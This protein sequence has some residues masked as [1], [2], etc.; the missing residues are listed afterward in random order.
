MSVKS[1][2]DFMKVLKS[3]VAIGL[4]IC[5]LTTS[6]YCSENIT[7]TFNDVQADD[8]YFNAVE[9]LY[10]NGIT[11]GDGLGNYLPDNEITLNA[12]ATMLVRAFNNTNDK[13]GVLPIAYQN[14]WIDMYAVSEDPNSPIKRGNVYVSI[15]KAAEIDV[16]SETNE[17]PRW[18]DY[19]LVLN[20]L[21]LHDPSKD[22]NK[23]ITRKEV[24]Q[25]LYFVLNEKYVPE[26]P[27][28]LKDIK[29][30]NDT[31][32][33][34]GNYT[35]DFS[36]IPYPIIEKFKKEKWEIHINEKDFS[37]YLNETGIVATGLCD[38]KNK[39]ISLKAPYALIHE[40]GHFIDY[41]SD[42]KVGLD[43]LYNIE[44]N[45]FEKH[46]GCKITNSREYFANYFECFIWAKTNNEEY[47]FLTENTPKTF[48]Y[49][50]NL[51]ENNW[52]IKK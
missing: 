12:F 22:L 1:D 44:G 32:Q 2:N 47:V 45:I 50:K 38:Y 40:F 3:L 24:A 13:A 34:L 16:F 23:G 52:E 49:F 18:E 35:Y 6:A 20:Q 17:K 31:S 11:K 43:E 14:G 39:T 15:F 46:K 10:K 7:P 42:Y 8:D 5:T 21:G 9:Y 33:N 30:I 37:N 27:E 51:E 19:A 28:I 26:L 4:I 36:K 29:I 48:E 25:I 41:M